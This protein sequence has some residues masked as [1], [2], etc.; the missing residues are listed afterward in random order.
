MKADDLARAG[1]L[2]AAKGALEQFGVS[3]R[4]AAQ[5][6]AAAVEPHDVGRSVEG[7]EHDGEP[8]VRLEMGGGLVAA[9][10]AVEIGDGALVDDR[11]RIRPSRRHVDA[12]IWGCGSGEENALPAYEVAM[13][14][15][16]ARKLLAHGEAS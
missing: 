16:E 9:A 15:V 3:P 13:A 10:G 7:A 12:R 2:D 14:G 6:F 1:R 4:A 11:E 8:A 5:R